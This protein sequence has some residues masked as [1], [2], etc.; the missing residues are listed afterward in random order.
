MFSV[1]VEW[2]Y[3]FSSRSGAGSRSSAV[4]PSAWTMWPR[5]DGSSSSPQRSTADE[6]GFENWPAMRPTL[7]TGSPEA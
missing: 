4:R 6:R 7:T 1:P 5:N 3:A 2:W